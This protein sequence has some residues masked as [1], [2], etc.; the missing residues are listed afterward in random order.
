MAIKTSL[1]LEYYLGYYASDFSYHNLG[2]EE[3][4]DGLRIS[5]QRGFEFGNSNAPSIREMPYF[6]VNCMFCAKFAFNQIKLVF[7]K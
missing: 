3:R 4:W 7:A 1:S 5:C 2:Q 6:D